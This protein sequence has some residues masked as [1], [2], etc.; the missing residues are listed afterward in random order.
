MRRWY[1]GMNETK[2]QFSVLVPVYNVEQ[3][4]EKCINSILCQSFSDFELILVDDGSTDRSG[5][6]CDDYEKKDSRI[7]VIHKEN[8]GLV[9]ARKA[10]AR[11]AIGNYAICVDS[12]DWIAKNHLETV[13]RIIK[14]YKPD[15]ICFSHKEV[16]NDIYKERL[17][18][19]REGLYSRRQIETDIFPKLIYG[20]N[21][22]AFPAAIWSKAFR[23]SLY[24]PEQLSV[25]DQIKIGEDVACVAPCISKAESLYIINKPLYYYRRNNS[26]MTKNKKPFL[27]NGPELI[28]H[29][30]LSRMDSSTFNFE[31]QINKR[32]AH[33]LINVVKTQF[34]KD[35]SYSNITN[36]IIQNVENSVYKKAINDCMFSYK[37]PLKYLAFCLKN[38]ILFPF[39][40]LAKIK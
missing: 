16:M 35:Q 28:Y 12:D 32:T 1:V 9:S 24:K 3:Y 17:F 7:R 39:W 19:Y 10:G 36:I 33:A 13:N 2:T 23:M 15:V 4:L 20:E 22:S 5:I 6:I 14:N 30:H 29:H 34:Y 11:A 25:D 31:P 27:W 18:H 37:S 21:G 8:G 40:L 38:K 26:S